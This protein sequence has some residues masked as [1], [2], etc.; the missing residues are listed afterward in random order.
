LNFQNPRWRTA[1]ILKKPLNRHI[2]ATVG[3]ILMK[4]GTVT[5]IAPYR[6][7]TVKMLHFFKNQDGG[8]RHL[9]K[10]QKSR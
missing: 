2:S 8:G 1:A 9:E 6:R 10:P 3:P 5:Q 7:Q 4:F